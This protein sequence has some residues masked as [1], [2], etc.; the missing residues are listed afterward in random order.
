MYKRQIID[1]F[2]NVSNP[3]ISRIHS[4]AYDSL[5]FG[6]SSAMAWSY[7]LIILAVLGIVYKLVSRF[8]FYH[9]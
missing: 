4:S 6:L 3:V 2:T 8:I 9:E 5:N 7:M 1:S